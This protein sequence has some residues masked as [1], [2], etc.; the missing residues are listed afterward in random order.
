MDLDVE[1]V[2]MLAQ[3]QRAVGVNSID[4]Y[5][6][7]IGVLAQIKPEVLDKLDADKWADVYGDMLGVDPDLIVSSENVAIVRQQRAQAQQQAAQMESIERQATA[8]QKLGTVKTNEQNA[9]TDI[10][11]L[12]SGYQSPSGTEL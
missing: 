6:A 1:F 3:A 2:S 8:A 5:V 11:N 7:N 4:R 9:A 12:F 10:I